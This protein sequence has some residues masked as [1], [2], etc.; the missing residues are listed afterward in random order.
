MV[1][2]YLWTSPNLLIPCGLWHRKYV[3]ASHMM[4]CLIVG[5]KSMPALSDHL[6]WANCTEKVPV[7]W[8]ILEMILNYNWKPIVSQ[9]SPQK[10]NVTWIYQ[11]VPTISVPIFWISIWEIFQGHPMQQLCNYPRKQ[12][13]L[14]WCI[15]KN[16]LPWLCFWQSQMFPFIPFFT[17][18]WWNLYHPGINWRN[19]M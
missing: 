7:P 11:R 3:S 16:I 19:L 17:I 10:S 12:V 14:L 2:Y 6:G 9:C 13:I 15:L 1:K 8:K 18:D 4:Q 5:A